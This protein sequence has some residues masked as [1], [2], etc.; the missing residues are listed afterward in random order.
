MITLDL[1]LDSRSGKAVRVLTERLELT[2]TPGSYNLYMMELTKGVRLHIEELPPD[3]KLEV[4]FRGKEKDIKK[5]GRMTWTYDDLILPGQ[6]I[7]I[8]FKQDSN[9]SGSST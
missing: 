4:K 1:K 2:Y 8:M 9:K 5:A 7:E 3:I 6:R